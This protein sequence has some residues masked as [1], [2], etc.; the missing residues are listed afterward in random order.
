MNAGYKQKYNP[1]RLATIEQQRAIELVKLTAQAMKASAV[2]QR[3]AAHDEA[4]RVIQALAKA[5][6]RACQNGGLQQRFVAI[7]IVIAQ[8]EGTA[9][10][11]QESGHKKLGGCMALFAL[12]LR[13]NVAVPVK[14]TNERPRKRRQLPLPKA[15]H[16]QQAK[17]LQRR[18]RAKARQSAN[19]E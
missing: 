13:A 19:A 11:A 1:L 14:M 12:E 4:A 9:Q 3:Q 10:R 2:D 7:A 17:K 15:G 6:E 18:A 8:L 16:G 5:L